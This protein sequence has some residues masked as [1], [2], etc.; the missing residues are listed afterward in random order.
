MSV[1]AKRIIIGIVASGLAAAW[2]GEAIARRKVQRGYEE[3]LRARRKLEL[4]LGG[5]RAEREQLAQSLTSEQRRSEE[6]TAKLNARDQE[7]R[8]VVS[9]L[10][11]E[12]YI[13]SE[14]QG[15]VVAMQHQLDQLQGELAV[16]FQERTEGGAAAPGG[17]VHLEKV[18][19]TK[20]QAGK[21]ALNGRVLSVHPEWRFV[22]VDIGWD[23]VTIGDV[24]SIYRDNQLLGKA[25]IERVQEQVSAATLLPEWNKS[26]IKINDLVRAL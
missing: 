2:I 3:T 11:Q 7:L 19:V 18:V 20:P 8:E 26:E 12:E 16:N 14:L 1:G 5:L 4:E 22:V 21:T 6:L 25:R 10:A 13:V 9:R 24:V 15:R 17:M 23:R